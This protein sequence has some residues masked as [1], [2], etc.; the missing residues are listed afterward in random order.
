[1]VEALALGVGGAWGG[2]VDN[3]LAYLPAGVDRWVV[4]YEPGFHARAVEAVV[5]RVAVERLFAAGE[6]DPDDVRRAAE[7]TTGRDDVGYLEFVVTDGRFDH[8]GIDYRD[9]VRPFASW[10]S[11]RVRLCFDVWD[12]VFPLLFAERREDLVAWCGEVAG[13]VAGARSFAYDGAGAGALAWSAGPWV[14]CDGATDADYLLP[15]GEIA[16]RPTG[17]DGD[18]DVDGWVIGSIPFGLKYGRVRRGSLRLRFAGGEVVSVGGD[19]AGLC[20]DVE[21]VMER[22]PQLRLVSEVGIGQSRAAT[23]ASEVV[24]AGMQWHERRVGLHVGLGAELPDTVDERA[25]LTSHHLDLVLA[26]GTVRT[27]CGEVVL[28]W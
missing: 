22:V 7:E 11:S 15:V 8:G 2:A 18:L 9:A 14:R 4:V 25:H 10:P 5:A 24:P 6:A 16:C 17:L 13:R 12:D 3:F 20:A 23:A 27:G 26:A 19:H 21:M 28:A 1:M